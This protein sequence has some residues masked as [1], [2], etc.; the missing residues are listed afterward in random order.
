[1]VSLVDAPEN[2]RNAVIE[3]QTSVL[4][5]SGAGHPDPP[6]FFTNHL[7]TGVR[8][9]RVKLGRTKP[10]LEIRVGEHNILR[11]L[12][13]NLNVYFIPRYVV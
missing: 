1:M 10:A 11:C 6:I 9:P 12:K 5:F 13:C 8:E 7:R 4:T 2:S 3:H